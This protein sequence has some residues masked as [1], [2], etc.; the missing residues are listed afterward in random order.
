MSLYLSAGFDKKNSMRNVLLG[1]F[2]ALL[3]LSGFSASAQFSTSKG[4]DSSVG[5]YNGSAQLEVDNDIKSSSGNP[6]FIK[7]HVIN[8]SFGTGW[9]K[10]GSGFCDNVLCYTALSGNTNIFDDHTVQK[11]DAYGSNYGIFHMVFQTNNPSVGSSAW[12]QV[13]AQ[14]T[15]SGAPART[16]TFVAYAAAAGVVNM[17]SSDDVVLY[18]NPAREAVNVVYDNRAGIKTIAIYNLIGKM[19]SPLYKPTANGSAKIDI[20]DMPSGVYFI[21][22]MDGQGRTIATR[23]FVH[24]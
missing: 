24:Q 16:L 10:F 15:V 6:V 19:V 23:R 21:R 2:S 8:S 4:K 1:F 22:L 11:S 7:W 5:Y 9:E 20:N 14:D 3:L 17:S 13:S 12:V 18:P